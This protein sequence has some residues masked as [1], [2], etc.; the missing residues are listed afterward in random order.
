MKLLSHCLNL[1]HFS[2]EIIQ[3]WEC[4]RS[5]SR[6]FHCCSDYYYFFIFLL[7]VRRRRNAPEITTAADGSS[8]CAIPR[9]DDVIGLQVNAATGHKSFGAQETRSRLS[10]YKWTR[11]QVHTQK[12]MPHNWAGTARRR[13]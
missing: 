13:W 10:I 1:R 9:G 11:S 8:L 4:I 2:H 7:G 6:Y 5:C 3:S 12:I